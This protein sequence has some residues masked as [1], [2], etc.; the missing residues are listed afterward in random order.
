MVTVW[1][2]VWHRMKCLFY[3]LKLAW[4][5]ECEKSMA[6]WATRTRA[7]W[8]QIMAID[9]H[10]FFLCAGFLRGKW[11]S[12]FRDASRAI[13][14]GWAEFILDKEKRTEINTFHYHEPFPQAA[15]ILKR[16]F[17]LCCFPDGIASARKWLSRSIVPFSYN[18]PCLFLRICIPPMTHIE[19]KEWWRGDI[20]I[21][22]PKDQR[23]LLPLIWKP[24]ATMRENCCI[25]SLS[26]YMGFGTSVLWEQRK[27]R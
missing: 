3:R 25:A 19:T 26:Q 18:L 11:L 23:F 4:T 12:V 8:H 21:N 9:S 5:T 24:W 1:S 17:L 27:G 2:F 16:W 13:S 6:S 14:Q 22:E 15:L 20:E 7:R 10:S